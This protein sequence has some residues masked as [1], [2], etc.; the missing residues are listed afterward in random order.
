MLTLFSVFKFLHIVAAIIWVG[1]VITLTLLNARLASTRNSAAMAALASVGG[2]FSQRVFGPAAGVTLLAGLATALNAGFP[3]RSAW[4]I[5]GF[6]V[7]VLSIG[8]NLALLRPTAQRIGALAASP[9]GERA[10]LP[11]L[12]RRLSM[13]TALNILLLLSAIWAM[14]AKPTL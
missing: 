2:F 10:Q 8:L 6:L 3:M 7:I 14:V 4:I 1:G 11:A 9:E 12:Q 5:W 13:L